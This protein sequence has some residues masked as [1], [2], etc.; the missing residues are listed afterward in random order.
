MINIFYKAWSFKG[1]YER[2]G[3]TFKLTAQFKEP[4]IWSFFVVAQ[5]LFFSK[6]PLD[7]SLQ[8]AFA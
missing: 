7:G 1:E 6:W 3:L 8:L 4:V 2:T 5:I